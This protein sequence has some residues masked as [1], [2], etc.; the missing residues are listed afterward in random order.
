VSSGGVGKCALVTGS[1]RGIGR[2]IALKLAEQG[3]RVAV[4]YY[5]NESAAN[6]TLAGIRKC[7][8]D[9]FVVQGDVSRPEEVR[10]LFQQ[11]EDHFGG[12]DIFVSNARPELP[13]FYQPPLE[14]TL[15]SWRMALDSQAAAFLVGAQESS[16]LMRLGGRILAV[17]Y[18]PSARTGSWQ[19]WVAMGAGKAAV[20]ALVRYFAV[21]L[22]RRGITVNAISPGLTDDSVLNGLPQEV[23]DTAHA[24]HASGWTPMGR[25]GTPADIG[26][27]VSLLCSE[28]AAWITGQ[29]IYADGGAS[30]MDTVFPLQIQGAPSR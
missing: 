29:T 6:D 10:R 16:R 15:D 9:G 8:S 24:W 3:I 4:H 1:S 30:L 25:L 5:Q 7:E 14:I 28:P 20:E 12:L 21:A 23:Q 19:P 2:G 22:A 26:G 13:T 18:A 17:T 27:V 11:V